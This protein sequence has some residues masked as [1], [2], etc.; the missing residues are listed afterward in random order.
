MLRDEGWLA[1]ILWAS[2]KR[3]RDGSPKPS[4]RWRDPLFPTTFFRNVH[5]PVTSL[6][7][8]PSRSSLLHQHDPGEHAGKPGEQRLHCL[9]E[10]LRAQSYLTLCDSM[11]CSPPGSSVHEIPQARILEWVATSSS[12]G[13]SLPR[14]LTCVSCTSRIG[15]WILYHCFIWKAEHWNLIM[16]SL[17]SFLIGH[18]FL[19]QIWVMCFFKTMVSGYGSQ[20]MSQGASHLK[21]G[22]LWVQTRK[23]GATILPRATFQPTLREVLVQRPVVV[24]RPSTSRLSLTLAMMLRLTPPTPD[25]L[26]NSTGGLG[27]LVL[28]P[29]CKGDSWRGSFQRWHWMVLSLPRPMG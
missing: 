20:G 14:N 6:P 16:L 7:A 26:H 4:G 21:E 13:S 11:G 8:P 18:I 29:A 28:W 19:T 3:P 5:T 23:Q 15:R 10:H 1:G 27:F 2:V 12:R 9:L 24:G 17:A 25:L 22:P